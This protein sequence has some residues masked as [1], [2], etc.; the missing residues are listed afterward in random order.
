MKNF[1]LKSL[2]FVTIFA[3]AFS[4]NIAVF[5]AHDPFGGNAQTSV[6]ICHQLGNGGYVPNSPN[7]SASG[8]VN[9]HGG[10]ED[11]I[12][13]PFHY[14]DNDD[15]L[16]SYPGQNWTE[17]NENLW[18]DNCGVGEDDDNESEVCEEQVFVSEEGDGMTEVSNLHSA[19]TASI[20]GA[21]WVWSEDPIADAVNE[22]TKTFTLTF[23]VVGDPVDAEL[24]I[25]ADNEYVVTVNG[26]YVVSDTNEDNYSS[27]GQDSHT[28]PAAELVTGENTIEFEVTNWADEAGT[29]ESNPAGLM[30]KL[31]VDCEDEPEDNGDTCDTEEGIQL[32]GCEDEDEEEGV[33]IPGNL[34]SNGGFES[35]D[36]TNASGW[37]LYANGDVNLDWA[38]SWVNPDGN[39][40]EDANLELHGGVNG[41]LPYE[42][43]QY[44]ELDTDYGSPAG[45]AAS[46]E[47]S[48]EID[49]VPGVTYEVS[50]AFSPRPDTALGENKLE[51]WVDG[52]LEQ[53]QG[54]LAGGGANSWTTHTYSFEAENETTTIAFKDEGT[55]NS[56]G[57][58]LDAVSVNC[59]DEPEEQDEPTCNSNE[60]WARVFVT[61]YDNV[62]TGNMTDKVYVGNNVTPINS[63]EWFM[64]HDGA[65]YITDATL[66]EGVPGLAVQRLNGQ[67]LMGLHGSHPGTDGVIQE[68]AEGYIEFFNGDVTSVVADIGQNAPEAGGLH[69]DTIWEASD[70]SHFNFGVNT[71]DDFYFTNYVYEVDE[72]C[73]NPDGPSCESDEIWARVV[74]TAFSNEGDGNVTDTIYLGSTLNTVA[75]GEWFNTAAL[76]AGSIEDFADVAG[77][78]VKRN[79]GGKLVLE[80]HGSQGVD[81]LESVDGH[82]EFFNGNPTLVTYATGQNKLEPGPN[83]HVD[84]AVISGDKVN[85]DL[86]VNTAD[87]RFTTTFVFAQDESCGEPQP[88]TATVTVCKQDD[89]QNYLSGWEVALYSTDSVEQVQVNPNGLVH[90]SAVYPA[91]AYKLEAN[92]TYIYRNFHGEGTL[93]L[94]ADAAYSLRHASDNLNPIYYSPSTL[95][96]Q[97]ETTGSLGIRVNGNGPV[98]GNVYNPAHQYF[99][100]AN[101]V[102]SDTFDFQILDNQYADNTG[103]LTV[104]IYPGYTGTTGEEGCVT[105]EDVPFGTYDLS[106]TMQEG[107]EYVSGAGEVVVDE[108]T[109]T[110]YVV[111]HD[112][113]ENENPDPTCE[114]L[115]NCPEVECT[116]DC[117]P[118][119][120]EEPNNLTEDNDGGSSSSG[121]RVGGRSGGG[122]VLG[123][124]TEALCE[125][126]IDTYMRLGYKN[127]PEQVKILQWL[128]NKYVAPMPPLPIDGYYGLTTEAAVRAFQIKYKDTILTPWNLVTPTG[129]FFR[130]TL[131]TA[132]NLECPEEIV[133]VPSNLIPWSA[134]A[135]VVP[136]KAQ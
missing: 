3:M 62:D 4:S 107:W 49:T 105:F 76:D 68:F 133:P 35:P 2:S 38:V 37:Q 10:H 15:V 66:F 44:A 34:I 96:Y 53:N 127:N 40:P 86:A 136:P 61:D 82:I 112:N 134:S 129:I 90:S 22:T 121:S 81:D 101:P 114:E 85:F 128:L 64:V 89:E 91:G 13:P 122:E 80:L 57:T 104:D 25:A 70:M 29:P 45:G 31:T 102:L 20:D 83:G 52:V 92:G 119:T 63:G 54:P 67:I 71:A 123:A 51:L 16:Q 103:F 125:F 27:A 117:E 9:G 7:I 56:V 88:E 99:S 55:P 98:W 30:Y 28:I 21:A 46:V 94:P 132:K 74:V 39:E 135:G 78:A 6:E 18:N 59:E 33:C 65:S 124:E 130:T 17:E 118:T 126:G 26:D 106:E 100:V 97:S 116:V 48:Q 75:S 24:D 47:I 77:L 43:S 95:W 73:G 87:D 12:I 69:P 42:G 41:W 1:L 79:A 84:S 19:W 115:E 5:A 23:D 113:N 32:N 8:Q 72:D 58:F 109:E 131:A 93:F 110:F 60:I 120:P 111:N 14:L 50:Y 11:D 108:A 36:V